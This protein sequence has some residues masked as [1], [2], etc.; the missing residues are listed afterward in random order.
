MIYTCSGAGNKTNQNSFSDILDFRHDNRKGMHKS[1]FD[2][3]DCQM[4]LLLP[5]GYTMRNSDLT[6]CGLVMPYGDMELGQHW[7]R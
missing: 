3:S 4:I 2:I 5:A 1:L 6:H 7:L